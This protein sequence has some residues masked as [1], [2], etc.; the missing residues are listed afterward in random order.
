MMRQL[1]ARGGRRL[2]QEQ[3]DMVASEQRQSTALYCRLAVRVLS[4]WT[5]STPLAQCVLPKSVGALIEFILEAVEREFGRE[6]TRVAL[7]CLTFSR[8]GLSDGK[9]QNVLSFNDERVLN[10]VFQYFSS[11]VRRFPLH[12]WLR[13]KGALEGL[14]VEREGAR[15][16]WYHRQLRE[17]AEARYAAGGENELAHQLLAQYFGDL[18][19]ARGEERLMARQPLTL[20]GGWVWF[21]SA[22]INTRRCVEA[23][24]HLVAAGMSMR[25]EACRELC[26]V[27]LVCACA[28][29]GQIYELL[30]VLIVLARG[31]AG[32]ERVDSGSAD[33]SV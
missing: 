22:K 32:G 5:S 16:V 31:G 9:M 27:E 13:L 25:E 14:L 28:K 23:P 30:K 21:S 15:A 6:W 4:T 18:C 3:W 10:H 2:T 7:A 19:G 12:V 8:A 20:D 24:Y 33:T 29:V 11:D 17:T 1:L 26:S